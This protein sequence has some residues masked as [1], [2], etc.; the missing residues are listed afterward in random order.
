[1]WRQLLCTVIQCPVNTIRVCSFFYT[2]HAATQQSRRHRAH[3]TPVRQRQLQRWRRQR[4]SSI[5]T[6]RG[7]RRHR[8]QQPA[9]TLC[10][11]RRVIDTK[12]TNTVTKRSVGK[13]PTNKTSAAVTEQQTTTTT[14]KFRATSAA[15]TNPLAQQQKQHA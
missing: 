7:W 13:K 10:I 6:Q 14:T 4:G 9:E 5:P 11:Q 1:M 2:E 15:T 8:G 12:Y 3:T